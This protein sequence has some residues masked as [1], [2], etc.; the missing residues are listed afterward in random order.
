MV[1][2]RENTEDIYVGIEFEAGTDENKKFLSSSNRPS[3]ILCKRSAFRRAPAIGIKPV[4][5]EG[6]ERLIRSAIEYAIANKRKSVTLVH[7]GN[8]QNSQKARFAIGAT[9][10]PSASSHPKPTAGNQWERT[11]AGKG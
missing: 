6:S 9:S 10:S 7:K 4:S 8:I 2:F 11:K 5:K 1:I 3:E